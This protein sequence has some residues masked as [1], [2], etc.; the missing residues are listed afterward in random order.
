MAAKNFAAI[1]SDIIDNILVI[2]PSIDVKI[3]TVVRDVFIDANAAELEILYSIVNNVS[4]AQSVTTAINAQLDRLAYNF[5]ITRNQAVRSAGTL[6][7]SIKSGIQA[8]TALNIGDQFNTDNKV[9]PK[10]QKAA[11]YIAPGIISGM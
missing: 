3:G 7:V 10:P 11:S 5:G 9:Y 6:T 2:N 4:M 1:V 8:P